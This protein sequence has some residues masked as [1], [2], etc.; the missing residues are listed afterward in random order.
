MN[1]FV[2][3]AHPTI[4]ASYLCDQHVNKMLLES[5]Q[6][7]STVIHLRGL[8]KHASS[9]T[10]LYSPT[11]SKHPCVRWA[12]GDWLNFGWLVHHAS[13][14][15]AEYSLRYKRDHASSAV[16]R[17]IRY[18][19]LKNIPEY[20]K[21]IEYETTRPAGLRGIPGTFV[22]AMPDEFKQANH[23]K[24][25]RDYYYHKHCAWLRDKGKGM[26]WKTKQPDWWTN[27]G[28]R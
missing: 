27:Y 9:S 6:I 14:I 20:L 7:L 10:R 12:C 19:V 4:A 8:A 2:L 11:H 15:G 3:D 1:I 5:A 16:V 23:V 28:P 25:Y 18:Y 21:V 24:A 13:A 22:L 17:D 26:T